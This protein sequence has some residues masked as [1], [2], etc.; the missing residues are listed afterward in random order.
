MIDDPAGQLRAL[1]TAAATSVHAAPDLAGQVL[2]RARRG[3][4][5]RR[6]RNALLGAGAGVAA[7]S[8]LAAA[9]LLGQSDF[10]TVTEPSSAMTPTVGIGERVVFDRSLTPSRGDVVLAHLTRDGDE[11]DAIFRVMGMPGD[12]VACPA[13][14]P[15]TCDAVMVNGAAVPE[16]YLNQVTAPFAEVTVPAG[17]VFLLG[18]NRPGANDSRYGGPV[19]LDAVD[20][21]AVRI[22]GE[23]GT[24]RPVPGAPAHDGPGEQ[25]NVDPAGPV[26]PARAV[27]AD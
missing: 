5:S 12:T 2:L 11:Y 6:W 27:P 19:P 21:V 8:T 4:R 7:L 17:Q 3:R 23:D 1:A 14:A 16:P 22:K 9:T 25:D 20:A 15:G 13:T 26:P 10:F 24:V 18:D